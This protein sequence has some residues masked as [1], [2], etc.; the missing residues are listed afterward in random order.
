MLK[1]ITHTFFDRETEERGE[2]YIANES[3]EISMGEVP[4]WTE[5]I[6]KPFPALQNKNYQYYFISQLISL[7]GTWLQTV[8]QGIL[9]YHL[10][11]S[12]LWVGIIFALNS[13][14][15]MIFVLFGGVIVDRFSKKKIIILTQ[16]A[17]LILAF[18]LG[19]LT[20]THTAT[21]LW[22]SILT[23]LLGVVNALDL[24]AR[25]AFMSDIV[26]KDQL[27]SAIAMNAGVFNAA[28]VIG[29]LIAGILIK[30]VGEGGAFI[31]NAISFV[32]P[33]IALFYISAAEEV[34]KTHPHPI[35]AIKE[36]LEYSFT[37]NIIRD[38][39]IF[40]GVNS[41]FGWSYITIMP[42]IGESK[43]HL[44]ASGLSLLYAASGAG[45][46]LGTIAVSALSRKYSPA[47]FILGGI[48]L[49]A[50]SLFLFSFTDSLVFAIPLLF[51]SGFGLVSHFSMM[52][53]TIQHLSPK[54][55]MGR[56]LSVYTFMFLG[57]SP[58]GSFQIGYI[59][60]YFGTS[61]AL[62]IS[63]SVVLLFGVYQLFINKKLRGI[64]HL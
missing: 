33:I 38:L 20:L 28:R 57:L 17:S 3:G 55:M 26:E 7:I 21:V 36:G 35:R 45:S 29:P 42:V 64:K 58:I 27:S 34:P 62:Q 10:T 56:V 11:N 32:P 54:E 60:Q 51:L 48:V 30:L 4:L 43:F 9:V 39:M 5:K 46:V 14:P 2:K 40:A 22:I 61:L 13:V 44:D 18:I 23:F 15:V 24:P 12:A 53:S 6:L 25:Q 31:T 37:H 47:R 19:I 50:T 16:T 52:N 59:T 8:A 41:I 49:F 1:K 63:A